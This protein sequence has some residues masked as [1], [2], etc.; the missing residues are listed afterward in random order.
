VHGGERNKVEGNRCRKG[1]RVKDVFAGE[2][3]G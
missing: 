3:K 2:T 1:E